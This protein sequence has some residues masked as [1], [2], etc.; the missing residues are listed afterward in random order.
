MDHKPQRPIGAL[1]YADARRDAYFERLFVARRV[2]G[3]A[4]ARHIGAVLRARDAHRQRELAG[5]RC[6]IAQ[7]RKAFIGGKSNSFDDLRVIVDLT[8]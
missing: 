8:L 1:A 6:Q 4:A 3:K 5:T 2:Y 7:L